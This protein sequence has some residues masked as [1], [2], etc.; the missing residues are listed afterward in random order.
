M[1]IYAVADIHGKS[2]RLECIQNNVAKHSPNV[3][4]VAGDITSF[5]GGA[6]VIKEL[7]KLSL[8]VLAVR[9][10]TDLPK[11]DGLL[12]NFSNTICLHLK[13]H[14]IDGIPFV[15]YKNNSP[16]CLK[17]HFPCI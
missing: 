9:G 8:P 11:I 3:L 2:S 12:N 1:R 15:I 4:V 14:M 7:N 17:E 5:K 16:E 13:E 6:T 10:N